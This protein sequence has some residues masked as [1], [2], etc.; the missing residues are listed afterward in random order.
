M[1]NRRNSREWRSSGSACMLA[2]AARGYSLA[3]GHSG[4]LNA[5]SIMVPG[6]HVLSLGVPCSDAAATHCCARGV[7]KVIGTQLSELECGWTTVDFVGRL[8][9]TD[10][11]APK[12]RATAARRLVLRL[13]RCSLAPC[14]RIVHGLSLVK[15][16]F[17][18][19]IRPALRRSIPCCPYSYAVAPPL[20]LSP[21]LVSSPPAAASSFFL[22]TPLRLWVSTRILY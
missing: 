9:A 1:P 18:L 20:S 10:E 21:L 8:R 14:L 6:W 4:V 15:R 5:C 2:A 16:C 13:S 11:V 12:P 22:D 3:D 19:S 17:G 7:V